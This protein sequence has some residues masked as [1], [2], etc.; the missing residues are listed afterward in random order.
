MLWKGQAFRAKSFAIT[1]SPLTVWEAT[2]PHSLPNWE[3]EA[4]GKAEVIEQGF[5]NSQLSVP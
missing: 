1:V 2:H 3:T 4:K 5:S